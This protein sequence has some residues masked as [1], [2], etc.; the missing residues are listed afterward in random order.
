MR[1]KRIKDMLMPRLAT[2]FSITAA[3]SLLGI[4]AAFAA[5]SCQTTQSQC[6]DTKTKQTRTCTTKTCT[7]DSG[8]IVSSETII[9]QQGAGVPS[10]P[11][12]GEVSKQPPGTSGA[13]ENR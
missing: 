1:S 6:F 11:T 13:K 3:I 12:G 5:G 4:G 10:K 9:E 2:K 7:D 8:K